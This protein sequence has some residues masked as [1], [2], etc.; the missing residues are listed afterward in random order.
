MLKLNHCVGSLLVLAGMVGAVS[1]Q[2]PKDRPQT[3]NRPQPETRR[4]TDET[5]RDYKQHSEAD[6][7]NSQGVILIPSTRAEGVTV[8][9]NDGVR[10]GNVRDVVARG[11]SGKVVYILV[12]KGI[13]TGAQEP[14]RVAAVPYGAFRWNDDRKTLNL[15]VTEEQFKAAASFDADQWRDIG[16]PIAAETSYKY[17]NVPEERA[18]Q[19][20][21]VYRVGK[22]T[23]VRQ[24]DGRDDPS[25]RD[26]PTR[27][28]D[29]DRRDEKDRR[30]VKE[31]RTPEGRDQDRNDPAHQPAN[32][33]DRRHDYNDKELSRADQEGSLFRV[34]EIRNKPLTTQDGRGLG[35]VNDVIFDANSGRIAFLVITPASSLQAGDGRIGVPWPSF[36]V[37]QSGRL[38]ALDLD[39]ETLRAAPRLTQD[40]WAELQINGY[41]EDMYKRYG[42]DTTGWGKSTAS[43]RDGQSRNKYRTAMKS[44]EPCTV[45]GKVES[46]EQGAA[47]NGTD[48]VVIL[49]VRTD[50]G[51]LVPVHT[52]PQAYL[53]QNKLAVRK[54]DAVTITATKFDKDGKKC[55]CATEMTSP[56]GKRVVMQ[57]DDESK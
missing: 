17:F 54:G 45:R 55:V 28:D 41:T 23:E 51:E 33:E 57:S 5:R 50:D 21:K 42:Y 7:L 22:S 31:P 48:R 38:V 43:S 37:D 3:D 32:K 34:S 25:R 52:A 56:D 11:R 24:G 19:D 27:R 15:P 14:D 18:A 46:I 8:T 30:D 29:K 26:D 20:R 39:K 2:P 44:G 1:A 4:S 49:N 6:D 36:N 10:L 12:S 9:G 53:D 40:E 47:M 13:R 16:D 35:N